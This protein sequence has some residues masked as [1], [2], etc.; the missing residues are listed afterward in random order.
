MCYSLQC[1]LGSPAHKVVHQRACTAFI[2]HIQYTTR[3]WGTRLCASLCS[4]LCHAY[5]HEMSFSKLYAF[6]ELYIS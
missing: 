6:Q 3:N 2:V 1:S 5:L 4:V